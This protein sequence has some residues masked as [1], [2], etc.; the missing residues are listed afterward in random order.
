M[1]PAGLCMMQ[2]IFWHSLVLALF[3]SGSAATLVRLVNHSSSYI[4]FISLFTSWSYS[5]V[6]FLIMDEKN[7]GVSG[8]QEPDK[9]KKGLNLMLY[10]L[11]E[12]KLIPLKIVCF[13]AY[14]GE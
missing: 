7:N 2:T 14:A 12:R 6:V 3:Q 4:D 5:A 1:L 10:D 13:L 8:E 9:K 11:K